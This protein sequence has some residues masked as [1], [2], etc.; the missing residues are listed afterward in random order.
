VIAQAFFV[1]NQDIQRYFLG[2]LALPV[3]LD[4]INRPSLTPIP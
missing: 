4:S 1:W 2:Q 3:Q